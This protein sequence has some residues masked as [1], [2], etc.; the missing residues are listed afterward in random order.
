MAAK[1]AAMRGACGLA[2]LRILGW[3][4]VLAMTA[5]CLAPD[6]R[7]DA[8]VQAGSAQYVLGGAYQGDW[9]SALQAG[10]PLAQIAVQADA[11]AI[12]RSP[13]VFNL[14]AAE[15]DSAAEAASW[16]PNVRPV[17]SA[18]LD[19]GA[20]VVGLSV[21][22]LIYDFAQTRS[23][24]EQAEIRRV[25]TDLEFWAERNDTVRDALLAYL[26]AV[27]A[28]EI[29]VA[30]DQLDARLLVLA[31]REDDRRQSGVA[32]I[33]DALFVDVSRQEN[34]REV[35]RQQARLANAQAQLQREAGMALPAMADL[36]FDRV[37]G[38]CQRPAAGDYS[39]EMLRARM[40]VEL[41]DKST[42]EAESNLLPRIT[43]QGQISNDGTTLADSARIG[44]EGGALI[45]GGAQLRADAARQRALAAQQQLANLAQDLTRDLDR[46]AIEA[47]ALDGRLRE[48]SEL[49]AT[50][51]QTLDLFADR[52]AIGAAATSEAARLEVNR[53]ENIIAAAETRAEMQRNCVQAARLTGALAAAAMGDDA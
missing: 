26:D 45:G 1:N 9:Q 3:G 40:A 34:R 22:Q 41:A 18:G 31:A 13:N 46:L 7:D 2:R 21:T 8:P 38:A 32:S 39:P 48:Y 53:A 14:R 23:R 27:A 51:Q 25:M 43:A 30:R 52:F 4:A 50:T 37:I 5:G 19:G 6:A 24:R 35:I 11:S 15:A 10:L 28:A 47:Q 42:A 33:S 16:F 29:L 49:I 12:A 20:P 36:R 17:A 44:L